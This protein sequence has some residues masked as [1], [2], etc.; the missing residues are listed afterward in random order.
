MN[1][2]YVSI[3]DT[4]SGKQIDTVSSSHAANTS[5]PSVSM[6]SAFNQ[7]QIKNIWGKK[8]QQ[9]P[10]AKLTLLHTGNC[11]HSVYIEFTAIYVSFAGFPGGSVVQNPSA[12]V[13]DGD[14]FP[15]SGRALED[16]NPLQYSCLGNPM[17]GAWWATV[18]GLAKKS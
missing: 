2:C 10:K 16:G 6:N 1:F 11:L 8:F 17:Q 5:Q 3:S 18:F 12:N 4:G 7:P 14:S 13:G 15:G 9:F